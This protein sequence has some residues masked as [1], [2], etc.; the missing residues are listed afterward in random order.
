[1]LL[2]QDVLLKDSLPLRWQTPAEWSPVGLGLSFKQT[3]SGFMLVAT[4]KGM[5]N[6]SISDLVITNYRT[7]GKKLEYE[8]ERNIPK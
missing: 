2:N 5:L 1:M 7:A 8:K 6:N 4:Y 3:V